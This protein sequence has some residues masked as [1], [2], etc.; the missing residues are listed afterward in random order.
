MFTPT[1]TGLKWLVAG[2]GVVSL[3]FAAPVTVMA[4]EPST[5]QVL[6]AQ[7]S[8][9]LEEARQQVGQAL[10]EVKVGNW[11]EAVTLLEKA[12]PVYQKSFGSEYYLVQFIEYYL[13][14]AKLSI[15]G[16]TEEAKAAFEQGTRLFRET[17]QA[18]KN[19]NQTAS[20]TPQ[21]SELEEAK[22]LNQQVIQLKQ[23]GKYNEAIP[24]AERVLEIQE[25]ILGENH[26]DV[27]VSLNNLAFLYDTQRQYDK[28]E[29]LH[30]RSL[31]IKEGILG[32]NH[33][34]VAT[35][36]N[37]L[38]G[39]YKSQRQYDK[40]EALY[41]RSLAIR[42]KTLGEDHPE[43]AES[44]N[45]LATLY[46][47][48]GQYDKAEIFLQRAL[49]INQKAF[50]ENHPSVALS[51][52]NL[53]NLYQ[54]Q[55]LYSKAE[56][57][58]QRSLV[59]REKTLG[60]DHP[61]VAISLNNLAEV[62]KSQGRY[63]KAEPLMQRSLAI[64]EKAYGKSHP[65]V[66]ISLNNLA[67]LY[68]DQG[69]Y[70]EA[71]PFFQRSLAIKE[72]TLGEDHPDVALALNNLANLYNLQGRYDQA[73]PFY[74]RSL[75]ILEK[76]F[77]KDHPDVAFTLNNL[78]D[79]YSKQGRYDQAEPLLQRSL[80]IREK[81]LR[82][83]HPDV[84]IALNNLAGLYSKQGRYDQAEPLLQRSLT[85]RE[86]AYG[87]NH[88]SVATALN[89][90]ANLYFDQGRYSKAEPFHERALAI[91]E[92]AFGADHPDIAIS[93]N[94]LA[95]LYNFQGRYSKAEPF[96]ERALAIREK[97]FGENHPSVAA[98]LNNLA[99]LYHSQRR[100]DQAE[101]LMQRSLA[102]SEKALGENHPSVATS[103]NN[104]A[105][106][107]RSQRRY[108]QAE[109]LYQ[110]S[111][112]IREKAWGADH[113]DIATSLNNLAGLYLAQGDTT[114]TINFLNQALEVEEQNLNIFLATGSELQKQDSMK[115]ISNT[116]DAAISLHLQ[117]APNNAEAARLVLTTILRRKARILDAVTN[118]LQLLRDNIT[119]ENQQL[120]DELNAIQ[121]QRSN[122]L[123]NPPQDL[124][125]EQY[126]QLTNNLKAEAEN[127]EAQLAQRS[128]EFRV[129]TEPV[130]IEKL[131]Q[132]IPEDTALV[133]IIQYKPYDT[134]AI[135]WGKPHYAA[136]IISANSINWVDLGVAEPIDQKVNEFRRDLGEKRTNI[137]NSARELDEMVMQPIREKL[138][139][140]T[141][142][143][144][145][146][147]GQ[148]NLIPFAA[149]M[150]ENNEYLVKNYLFTYLTTGRDLL[151]L[152]LDA[153]S[154][155][156]PVMLANPN[157]DAPGN[158]TGVQLASYSPLTEGEG[159]G[160]RFSRPNLGEESGVRGNQRSTDLASLTFDP[161]EGTKIEADAILPVIPNLQL[162][163][164]SQATENV[165]KQLQAPKILH[166]ATHGFFLQ[167]VDCIP[168]TGSRSPNDGG[169]NVILNPDF[170]PECKPTPSNTENPLLRSGLALAGANPRQSGDE[171]GVLTASEVTQLRLY[172][173]KLVVLSACETGVGSV[174][175]GEGV[176]G[177]RR[178]FVKSGAESQLM[179]LWKVDDYGTSELMS[180]YYQRIKKGEGRS[181]AMRQVQLDLL[182]APAYQHPFYW[183]SFIFS[184]DWR[185]M[186]AF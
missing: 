8:D 29:L 151:K 134:K 31:A 94:N 26:L 56:P 103:L 87:E 37:N 124:P 108:D 93:L 101:P 72:K 30:Q 81:T 130:T 48:Q 162:L 35:S 44:L 65:R 158:S 154:R 173:T 112:A 98:S 110:R 83:D 57:L 42:E 138:G 68:L 100:Y 147:D 153:P 76:A 92:K 156:D 109:T 143:L 16:Q 51:L 53:A 10:E 152:Q 20:S 140:K 12:L 41:Q 36:L 182:Q 149:L 186:E 5:H 18:R 135:R 181:Q 155:Q 104:L 9:E 60:E 102:I 54:A 183:S 15:A 106:L 49:S 2:F 55:G 128:A 99:L 111:L 71:E 34:S 85:I 133:E 63:S 146:P 142:V 126:R 176:Y 21:S 174:A 172:G 50:E 24:L 119:P 82:A 86:K 62:Y 129:E 169:F 25:R 40:A 161:L 17:Q 58:L 180:L 13:E 67:N 88:P 145:S 113:P 165:L 121:S 115:A 122:L 78:A 77:G 75:A 46:K 11:E 105:L 168:V 117:D 4:E 91:R 141:H 131:Q 179:S 148:L 177:L 96:H 73:E 89:N 136:Y 69:R 159:S 178:A 171:D 59:I 132:L 114:Q 47:S 74:Q 28:A 38:A 157:Y 52:N 61:D 39:L 144:I 166:I 23:Q 90:L 150:D 137:E 79:L 43:V 84:A 6:L 45:N 164:G 95:N 14:G 97:A 120:L 27:A 22:R 32:E 33:P 184:G 64:W 66:A 107:Y 116:T 185:S 167:D 139:D 1:Q 163:T 160:E 118:E 123:Y 80:A 7:Q 125:P 175:N 70:S 19:N 170:Q 127:L 3:L